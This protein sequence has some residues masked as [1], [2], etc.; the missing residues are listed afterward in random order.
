M[1]AIIFCPDVLIMNKEQVTAL[2]ELPLIRLIHQAQSV[3]QAHFNP[4]Q[5]E[6]CSLLSIKTG[7]C[8][9]DCGY[10]SQSGHHDTGIK[11]EKLYDVATVIKHAKVAKEQGAT[12]FCM[13]A[14]FRSPPKKQL[15]HIL[16]MVQ[17]VKK[18]GLETCMTLGMLSAE[19]AKALKEAGLDYYNHNLYTS[20]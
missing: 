9:E 20:P 19:D 13:G 3:H 7:A 2:F 17:E 1:Q 8:P 18:L 4:D 14:A 11:T 16:K 10:C 6:L 5:I 15:P 12:R